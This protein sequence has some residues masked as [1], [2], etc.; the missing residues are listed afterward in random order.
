MSAFT[1]FFKRFTPGAAP[2]DEAAA[3]AAT[4]A[5]APPKAPNGAGETADAGGGD[6]TSGGISGFF[7]GPSRILDSVNTKSS[8]LI[9]DLSSKF[10]K[11]ATNLNTNGKKT[12]HFK[13]KENDD[14]SS[15]SEYGDGGDRPFYAEEAP[16]DRK[17]SLESL[18]SLPEDKATAMRQF[19]RQ[20]VDKIITN[21]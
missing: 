5:T 7:S 11:L 21:R 17:G 14:D 1:G 13:E 20:T 9:S 19:M 6:S 3:T 2:E 15:A 10:D 16:N 18:D 8:G 4:N 12:P